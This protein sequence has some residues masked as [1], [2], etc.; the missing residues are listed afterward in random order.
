MNIGELVL[1]MII[2]H[3]AGFLVLAMIVG[4]GEVDNL[5]YADGFSF[6]NP[7]FIY[8]Y[9]NVNWFGAILITI[10]YS[11]MMPICT[12][13]YWLYKLCTVGRE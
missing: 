13:G 7:C 3:I 8:E 4:I 10:F 9:T 1:L 12:A 11:L 2:W 6:V 5:E